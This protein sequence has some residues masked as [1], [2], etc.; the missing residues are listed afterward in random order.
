M[1]DAFD[2]PAV[3]M[4]SFFDGVTGVMCSYD[5]EVLRAHPSTRHACSSRQVLTTG[6]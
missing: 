1:F 5:Q 2:A 3:A 4:R 6:C